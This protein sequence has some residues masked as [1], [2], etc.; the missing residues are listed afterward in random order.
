MLQVDRLHEE[1]DAAINQKYQLVEQLQSHEEKL[2]ASVDILERLAISA[3]DSIRS[4]SI[5]KKYI[6]IMFLV[7]Q[8]L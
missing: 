2:E 7:I 5:H 8:I 4:I 3:V 1:Y 6:Y